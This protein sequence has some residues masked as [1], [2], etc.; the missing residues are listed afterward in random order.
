M[1][2]PLLPVLFCMAVAAA[3]A[4]PPQAGP[5]FEVASVKVA[6]PSPD[7][8]SWDSKNGTLLFKFRNEGGPGT[9]SPGRWTCTNIS[10]YQLLLIAWT[11]DAHQL[12]GPPSMLDARYD[13]LAKLPPGA[14]RADFNL[15]IQRLLIERIGLVAHHE[16]KELD[17]RGLVIAKGGPKMKPAEAALADAPAV[18]PRISLDKDGN[19]WLPP[20]YP[21]ATRIFDHE[22]LFWL[23]RMQ[24]IDEVIKA[25]P[26]T[27]QMIV[28]QTGL[29]G[30]YDYSVRLPLPEG[31]A[32]PDGAVPQASSPGLGAEAIVER[33]GLRLQPTK[34]IVDMLV[35]DRFNRVPTEN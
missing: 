21:F 4:Q 11:L 13:V 7:L 1:K 22:T 6:A 35:V 18:A 12:S 25:L 14:S 3:A 23:G 26:P 5:A 9:A 8:R 30:K 28:D 31:N 29:T 32:A 16:R 24:S 34:A 2:S 15:M 20:G 19:P 17:V 10:L 27:A 33:L